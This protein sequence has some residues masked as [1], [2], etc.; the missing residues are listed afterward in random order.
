MKK[1]YFRKSVNVISQPL[2]FWH[3]YFFFSLIQLNFR[4]TNFPWD[5]S[6]PSCIWS[7]R[8]IFKVWE[9]WMFQS[10]PLRTWVPSLEMPTSSRWDSLGQSLYKNLGTM[11][12]W[13][14]Y[15]F[16]L[17]QQYMEEIWFFSIGGS[18]RFKFC[19]FRRPRDRWCLVVYFHFLL[20][21][22][23]SK[24]FHKEYKIGQNS[25]L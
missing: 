15:I 8:S 13:D 17:R 22:H 3:S 10:M 23:F 24:W 21:T 1:L 4:R 5:L 18:Q 2:I 25:F 19:K 6:C 20:T 16:S 12:G 7:F 11:I 14:L 9:N